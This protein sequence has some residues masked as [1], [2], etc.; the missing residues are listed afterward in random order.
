MVW[1][2]TVLGVFW[3]YGITAF[4][5]RGIVVLRYYGICVMLDTVWYY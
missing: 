2:Y 1:R 5:Y 3:N 4:R